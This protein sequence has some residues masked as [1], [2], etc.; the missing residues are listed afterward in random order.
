[1]KTKIGVY[2]CHCGGNI[3]DYVDVEK[4]KQAIEKEEGV[5]LSKTTIFACADS[6]QKEMVEDI[7]NNNL[8]G[9]VVAS[10]SPKLHQITFRAVTERA[11]LNKYNY[12]HANIRE[13]ASWAHSDKKTE[14]TEKAIQIVKAAVAKA[15]LA[16]SLN[17]IKIESKKSVAVIG[18]GVAG[19][20]SALELANMGVNVHLIERDFFIGGRVAQW[21]NLCTSNDKGKDIISRLYKEISS[22]KNIQLYTGAEVISYSGSIGDFHLKLKI[23]PRFIHNN[24]NTEKLQK[25]I[26]ACPVEVPDAFNFNI[27]KRKAIYKNFPGEFPELPVIDIVSC[28]KCGVCEKICDQIDFSQKEEIIDIN[29]GSVLMAT[30]FDP[31]MPAEAEFGYQQS[32][33]VITLP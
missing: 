26:D 10:C 27:T 16:T 19:L 21:D 28:T 13:Q 31:Y 15:R 6:N 20:K 23:Q 25:A 7:K 3:S 24:S 17:P 18:A 33:N 5:S 14:A 22:K 9:V 11:G 32:D 4:V 30:G 2:I 29:I 12:V 8:E 1:M